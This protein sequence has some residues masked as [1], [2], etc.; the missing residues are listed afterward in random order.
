MKRIWNKVVAWWRR[1]TRLN[2]NFHWLMAADSIHP[3]LK[4]FEI[5]FAKNQ[6]E[7]LPLAAIKS[8]YQDGKV[9]TRW[10]LTEEMR[11]AVANGADIYL[12]LSTFHHPLQ[13]ISMFLTDQLNT[14]FVKAD[15]GLASGIKKEVEA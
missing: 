2:P 11:K 1:K 14:D 5:V 4:E 10:P 6:P 7:Y 15:Y 9:L 3:D 8:R 12:Q 13:P